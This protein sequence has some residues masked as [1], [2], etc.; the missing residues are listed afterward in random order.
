MIIIT[1]YS[2]ITYAMCES[3]DFLPMSGYVS[4]NTRYV[5]S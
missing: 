1:Y 3:H 4:D 2:D 5:Y